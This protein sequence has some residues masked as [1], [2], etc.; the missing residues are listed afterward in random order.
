MASTLS[1]IVNVLAQVKLATS[2]AT[3]VGITV[4]AILTDFEAAATTALAAV[5]IPDDLS[6]TLDDVAAAATALA[7]LAPRNTS[8]SAILTALQKLPSFA[9]DL[10]SG[11]IA[12][13]GSVSASFSGVADKVIVAAYRSSGPFASIVDSGTTD[14]ASLT[15]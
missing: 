3:A 11:Q 7:A 8:I 13:I 6:N 4:P 15:E 9:A 5:A 10:A 2:I 14:T 12:V 1:E